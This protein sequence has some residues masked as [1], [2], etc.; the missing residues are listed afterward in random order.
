MEE[1]DCQEAVGVAAAASLQRARYGQ[2][3]N[4]RLRAGVAAL[5]IVA[6]Q[7]GGHARM[8]VERARRREALGVA[9]SPESYSADV[10]AVH[11]GMFG[12]TE[13]G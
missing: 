5:V 9:S 8:L 12:V 13:E 7:V 6:T 2:M 3:V 1:I 10:L 4:A 11:M